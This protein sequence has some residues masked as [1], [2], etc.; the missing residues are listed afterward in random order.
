MPGQAP[1]GHKL[2]QCRCARPCPRGR[3]RWERPSHVSAQ[4][5]HSDSAR[6]LTRATCPSSSLKS[7]LTAPDT[8]PARAAVHAVDRD[9]LAAS[10]MLGSVRAG[11]HSPASECLLP[12]T[13]G[14]SRSFE[15]ESRLP[16][17]VENARSLESERRSPV[18]VGV[19]RS[20]ESECRSRAMSEL[21]GH[22]TWQEPSPDIREQ[23]GESR[24]EHRTTDRMETSDDEA[25]ARPR[26]S[27]PRSVIDRPAS[28]NSS[29]GPPPNDHATGAL[30]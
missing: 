10:P 28:T 5:V 21:P 24:R 18:A 23:N 19:A 13:V 22:L 17:T 3:W 29:D 16:V 4:P 9:D 27:S 12:V 1:L 25:A 15:S 2:V 30:P 14:V 6:S 26:S 20:L 11:F 7:W 8:V